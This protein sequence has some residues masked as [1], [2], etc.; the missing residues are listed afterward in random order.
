MGFVVI[1]AALFGSRKTLGCVL[2]AGAGVAVVDGVV[3][4]DEVGRGEWNHWGYAP[5]VGLVGVLLVGV[6]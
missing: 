1:A 3:V 5:V 6:V 2:L 4:R